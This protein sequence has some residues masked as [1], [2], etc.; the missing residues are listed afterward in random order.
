[1][2]HWEI[3]KSHFQQYY[4]YILLIIYFISKKTN[5][6]LTPPHIKMSPHCQNSVT[7]SFSKIDKFSKLASTHI[8][9]LFAIET[10]GTWHEMAT[11]LTQEIHWRSQ[12]F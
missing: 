12:D 6:N 4:P 2:C 10:A 1:M 3:Q 7:L 5:C 11:E 9:Y 8:F